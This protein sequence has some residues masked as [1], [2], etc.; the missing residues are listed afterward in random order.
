M[1]ASI[2][3]VMFYGFNDFFFIE[4]MACGNVLDKRKNR[5]DIWLNLSRRFSKTSL[6]VI[7]QSD[8]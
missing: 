7:I 1:N 6:S 4:Q 3:M 2:T 8:G 5:L